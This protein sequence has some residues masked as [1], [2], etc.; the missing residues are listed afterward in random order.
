MKGEK[1]TMK[2]QW[3]YRRDLSRGWGVLADGV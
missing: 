2:R 1:G 3:G